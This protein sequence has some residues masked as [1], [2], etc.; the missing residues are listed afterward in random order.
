V[1][2]LSRIKDRL[3]TAAGRRIAEDRHRIMVAFFER[4]DAEVEGSR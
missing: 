1:V 3:Y 2:K 4:L